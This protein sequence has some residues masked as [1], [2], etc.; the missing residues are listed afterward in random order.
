[1]PVSFRWLL[2]DARALWIEPVELSRSARDAAMGVACASPSKADSIL[3]RVEDRGQEG[4]D[5]RDDGH[6]AGVALGTGPLLD[7]RL[8]GAMRLPRSVGF[9]L[10]RIRL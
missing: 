5:F 2:R 7:A 3:R 4:F 10:R 1:M 6:V 8:V 9:F